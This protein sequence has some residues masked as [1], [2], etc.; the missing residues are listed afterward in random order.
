M[1]T[2]KTKFSLQ[3]LEDRQLMTGDLGLDVANTAAQDP[4]EVRAVQSADATLS[5]APLS[6]NVA[7]RGGAVDGRGT[8]VAEPSERLGRLRADGSS[9]TPSLER[10]TAYFSGH[11]FGTPNPDDVPDGPPDNPHDPPKLK[12]V[13]VVALMASGDQRLNSAA[14]MRDIQQDS[15]IRGA[16]GTSWTPNPDAVPDDP[17]GPPGGSPVD[18]VLAGDTMIVDRFTLGESANSTDGI[19]GVLVGDTPIIVDTNTVVEIDLAELEELAEGIQ[20][21]E[22]GIIDAQLPGYGQDTTLGELVGGIGGA[23][24]G[25]YLGMQGGAAAGFL[26]SGLNPFGAIAGGIT[27]G[28]SG[29]GMGWGMGK[30]IGG[31]FDPPGAHP[32]NGDGDGTGN[33]T[34]NGDS[35]G[36]GTGHGHGSGTGA[37]NGQGDG[38]GDGNGDANGHGTETGD[39]D[40]NGDGDGDGTGAGTDGSGDSDSNGTD[41][42]GDDDD[43]DGKPKPPDVDHDWSLG[44]LMNS[45]D[46]TEIEGILEQSMIDEIASVGIEMHS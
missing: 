34:G 38:N 32:G 23:I 44:S 33:Q 31:Y 28:M 16:S 29:A 1:S 15:E 37:G 43:K 41:D 30:D 9:A 17:K 46:L 36:G 2:K 27:G 42:S 18:P 12:P 13:D 10:E 5:D 11:Q 4:T 3:R 7:S 45:L 20:E 40:G 21:I 25:G 14:E 24:V 22:E 39:G 8:V 19:N 6:I 35:N 26:G